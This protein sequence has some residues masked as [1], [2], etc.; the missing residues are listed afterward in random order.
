M[1]ESSPVEYLGLRVEEALD[2]ALQEQSFER[3]PLG[4]NRNYI[5][6]RTDSP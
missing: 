4:A 3:L 6:P 1:G 2:L 5:L